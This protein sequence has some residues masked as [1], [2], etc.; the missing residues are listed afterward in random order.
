MASDDL[1]RIHQLMQ[2]VGVFLIPG[3]IL[4]V[5]ATIL[6]TG[7]RTYLVERGAATHWTPR[8][9]PLREHSSALAE[10]CV[11]PPAPTVDRPTATL[12]LRISE[13]RTAE[14][15]PVETRSVHP[16]TLDEL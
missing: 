10:D 2:T 7:I 12:R 8:R 13:A 5:S 4:G 16:N 14:F 6:L 9:R 11:A 15:D 3:M 1:L